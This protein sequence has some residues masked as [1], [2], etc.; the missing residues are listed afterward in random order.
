MLIEDEIKHVIQEEFNPQLVEVIN[1]SSKH[2]GHAGDDGSG[3]THFKVKVVAEAFK[4]CNRIQRQRM[5]NAVVGGLFTK[6]LH[7]LSLQIL[8]PD[9]YKLK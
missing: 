8:T 5:V 7:A 4:E 3:Q 6:G 1:E 2:I 9:E